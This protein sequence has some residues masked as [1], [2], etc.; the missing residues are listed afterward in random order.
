MMSYLAIDDTDMPDTIGTGRLSRQIADE[1]GKKYPVLFV[2]RHQFYVHPDIPYTSH[3]SGAVIH[4]SY[5]PAESSLL[6]CDEAISLLR[7]NFI[8]GSD[9]GLCL[10]RHDQVTAPLITYG[11]DAKTKILT[12]EQAL[13]LADNLNIPLFGLG[14]TNGGIIGALAGAALAASGMDGRYLEIGTIR[15][16]TGPMKVSDL[17]KTGIEAVISIDGRELKEGLVQMRKF[18]QPVRI[19]GKPILLVEEIE[20]QWHVVKRD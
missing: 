12:Q 4:F 3:N 1:L 15:G 14:G 9:P 6:L 11:Q 8:H 13:K 16:K 2:T 5:I 19:F 18:P 7:S 10:V 17:L 20:G